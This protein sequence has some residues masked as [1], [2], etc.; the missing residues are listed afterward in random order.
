MAGIRINDVLADYG[1]LEISFDMLV[2]KAARGFVDL[3]QRAEEALVHLQEC[4]CCQNVTQVWQLYWRVR[5]GETLCPISSDQA[6]VDVKIAH[7]Q[8]VRAKGHPDLSLW[9]QWSQGL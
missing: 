8:E 6:Q 1:G 2:G 7:P 9:S 4:S 3:G 5:K